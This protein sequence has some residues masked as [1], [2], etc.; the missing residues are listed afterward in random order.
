MRRCHEKPRE[1][2]HY[3]CGGGVTINGV[4]YCTDFS[5]QKQIEYAGHTF[6]ADLGKEENENQLSLFDDKGETQCTRG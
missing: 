4:R 2:N 5:I 1:N 6:C 3:C